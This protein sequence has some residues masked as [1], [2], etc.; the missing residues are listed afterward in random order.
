MH[1][2]L[3][4]VDVHLSSQKNSVDSLFIEPLLD[5]TL[6]YTVE[7]TE[8]QCSLN[9][10]PALPPVSFFKN[11][12]GAR[13]EHM[14]MQ[15]KRR[16][17]GV[18][19]GNQ[20]VLL[21][22][23]VAGFAY[24]ARF[25]GLDIFI[26]DETRPCQNASDLLYYMQRFFDDIKMVY[27][28]HNGGV[29]T[30]AFHGGVD[31]PITAEENFVTV[32][33]QPNGC[34]RMY[35]SPT[36]VKNFWI[37]LSGFG[38]NLLGISGPFAE[39]VEGLVGHT[40]A[41]IAFRLYGDDLLEGLAAL[42]VYPLIVLAGGI[43][44]T[45]AV[46]SAYPLERNFDHRFSLELTTALPIPPTIVWSTNDKQQVT[47]KLADFPINNT[48]RSTVVLN[49]EGGPLYC[50][51]TSPLLVG[52]LVWRRAEDKVT[53]RYEMMTSKFIQNI[54]VSVYIFRREWNSLTKTYYLKR[55]P[56]NLLEGDTW[57]AKL[58]FRTM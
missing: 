17:V 41:I 31:T 50:Y 28:N 34:F 20:A 15:V 44:D 46:Q 52:N 13:E 32:T 30:G 6:K 21:H 40:G 9:G 23:A 12:A 29:I 49:T 22:S 39:G 33:M 18:P 57:T 51:N 5:N 55:L 54:R 19:M 45:Q 27:V 10:E 3:D 42:Q 58:R 38:A 14:I 24:V 36:F 43:T 25:E 16:N 56:V 11:V 26:P 4:I 7:V 47:H 48:T 37:D 1:K 53:E 35:M 2:N 8:F